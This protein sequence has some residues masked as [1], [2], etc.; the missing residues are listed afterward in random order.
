L[1]RLIFDFLFF[2]IGGQLPVRG[3]GEK[4]V[5]FSKLNDST[6]R[7]RLIL[8]FFVDQRSNLLEP[9]RKLKLSSSYEAGF[10]LLFF[11]E[12]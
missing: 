6:N 11:T 12:W 10:P 2:F 7:E 8:V 1:R 9:W 4:G 5:G 3:E